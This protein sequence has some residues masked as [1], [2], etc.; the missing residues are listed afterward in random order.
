M[1]ALKTKLLSKICCMGLVF[2]SALLFT[3]G[4]L[5]LETSSLALAHPAYDYQAVILENRGINFNW[6][7]QQEETI[8]LAVD[9]DLCPDEIKGWQDFY[10]SQAVL[11]LD[12][13]NADYAYGLFAFT[14][15]LGIEASTEATSALLQELWK[16][17]RLLIIDNGTEYSRKKIYPAVGRFPVEFMFYSRA[18]AEKAA[19]RNLL[20]VTPREGTLTLS[21][22]EMTKSKLED[23]D[24]AVPATQVSDPEALNAYVSSAIKALRQDVL[25]IRLF[26]T[27]NGY[28]HL[29]SYF[30]L[31]L[32]IV[33]TFGYLQPL[34]T[35]SS[36]KKTLTALELSLLVFTV[37]RI[38]KL[39]VPI[40]DLTGL[41]YLW[42]AYYPCFFAISLICLLTAYYTGTSLEGKQI[43]SW[44]WG[45]CVID[46]VLTL[47]IFTNDL[48]GWFVTFDPQLAY[49]NCVYKPGIFNLPIKAL[50]ALEFIAVPILLVKNN[51]KAKFSY[52]R[53]IWPL[54]ILI[55]ELFFHFCYSLHIMGAQ[56][57]ETV[58]VTNAGV[59]LFLLA[60]VYAGIFPTNRG[61]DTAFT[62]STATMLICDASGQVAYDSAVKMPPGKDCRL[63]ISPIAGGKLYWQEDV[64]EI[65]RLRHSLALNNAALAR[66]N[67]LLQ[68]RKQV[69][70][71]LVEL[72][73][74]ETMFQELELIISLKK[75]KMQVLAAKLQEK[76]L[77]PKAK[78]HLVQL[79]SCLGIYIKKRSLLLLSAQ[80]HNQVST[81]EFRAALDE[82]AAYYQKAGLNTACCYEL[83]SPSLEAAE[84]MLLY[85]LAELV[86]EE[87]SKCPSSDLLVNVQETTGQL[88]MIIRASAE[89]QPALA[90]AADI[91]RSKKPFTGHRFLWRSA[92]DLV[93][94]T[95]QRQEEVTGS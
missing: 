79:F 52:R 80:T 2:M 88:K 94:L 19:G 82:S 23:R 77:A 51:V 27:D 28:E 22:G 53:I 35:R 90:K 87:S 36:L 44:W 75:E 60:S 43:P 9:K 92:E 41:R 66:Y 15:G 91:L 31:L 59:L 30:I 93:T 25:H 69:R 55:L 39:A 11:G 72:E 26:S 70:S 48:H 8:V 95:L 61:Y 45:L 14:Q 81:P 6:Y 3:L 73:L 1:H 37:I 76:N 13:D 57:M 56:N 18:A 67:R 47:L 24:A 84:A 7:P 83:V 5:S 40:S 50:I 46:L 86:W 89:L 58:W 10:A 38:L 71:H 20:L 65:N 42:Y 4:V 34:I 54:G 63:H 21:K 33:F 85:D 78:E 68:K 17:D 49:N 16:K 62:Y 12:T 32:C 74:Q 29:L 64:S